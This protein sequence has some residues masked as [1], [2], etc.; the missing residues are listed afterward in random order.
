[1]EEKKIVDWEIENKSPTTELSRVNARP[2][3]EEV[4]SIEI[5][6]EPVDRF[7][8][9]QNREPAEE[10]RELAEQGTEIDSAEEVEEEPTVPN[11]GRRYPL[12]ERRVP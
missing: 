3:R 7:N 1:M 2:T 5:E 11:G 9:R 6:S 10:Q 4:D 12:R 8:T